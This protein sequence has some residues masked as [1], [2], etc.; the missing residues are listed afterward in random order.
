VDFAPVQVGNVWV[1]EKSYKNA[2]WYTIPEYNLT[3]TIQ[4]TT[5]ESRNDTTY[6][7]ASVRD[8]GIV[9]PYYPD[10]NRIDV[11]YTVQGFKTKDTVITSK[12]NDSI[13][14]SEKGIENFDI[15]NL[16]PFPVRDTAGRDSVFMSEKFYSRGG[17]IIDTY[18]YFAASGGGAYIDSFLLLQ[19]T[20]LLARTTTSIFY[21]GGD[22]HGGTTT[23][24]LISFNGKPA[25]DINLSSVNYF[26][27]N[28][29]R[30]GNQTAFSQLL[31]INQGIRIMPQNVRAVFD[32]R[33]RAVSPSGLTNRHLNSGIYFYRD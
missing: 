9:V 16:F 13:V 33:G 11:K 14:V 12:A 29:R 15:G 2:V 27:Q 4:I 30:N 20:G 26:P 7:S 23:I 10:S 6:F 5:R 3:K 18:G 17:L 21:S 24:R 22:A 31:W 8:S 32:V 25:P 28:K 1:Y 19:N